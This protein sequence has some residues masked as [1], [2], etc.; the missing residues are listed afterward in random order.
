MR[1]LVTG[2]AIVKQ[3]DRCTGQQLCQ[4]FLQAGHEAVFYGNFHGYPNR[5]LGIKEAT[6][7]D[8]DLVVATEINDGQPQ[9]ELNFMHLKDVPIVYWDF[10]VSY[11]PE[12]AYQRA[13]FYKPNLLLVGN[14]YYVEE[15]AKRLEKPAYHLPYA[16]SPQIHRRLDNIKREYLIGFVGSLTPERQRLIDVC[17]QAVYNS[18]SVF[19]G[20]GYLGEDLITKTNQMS[21]MFHRNQDACRGLIPG[22]PWE[23]TGCGTTLMMDRISYEDFC[24]FLPKCHHEDLLVYDNETDIRGLLSNWERKRATLDIMGEA[25]MNYVHREHSYKRRAEQIIEWY[26]R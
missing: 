23:T 13:K 20:E 19:A 21:I 9:L 16:C 7:E 8:F 15:F 22:R 6:T 2:R 17:K 1:V 25:L 4:G 12:F 18:A 3:P 11:N 26:K 5:W 10:D 14:K 24:D